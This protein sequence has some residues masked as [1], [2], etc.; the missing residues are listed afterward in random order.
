[1][2]YNNHIP[3]ELFREL[4]RE[5]N[6][7]KKAEFDRLGYLYSWRYT[8]EQKKYALEMATRSGIRATA[9]ILE[10]PRR[11]I[12]RWRSQFHIEIKRFPDWV[13]PWVKGRNKRNEFWQKR[14]RSY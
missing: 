3:V 12:Q 14:S 7:D 9:R 11:T 1:M 4:A 8:D 10:I 13:Y 6:Q 2:N 5:Y